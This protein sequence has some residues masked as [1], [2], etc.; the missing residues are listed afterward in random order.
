[1]FSNVFA[2]PGVFI[3][4]F[5]YLQFMQTEKQNTLNGNRI[6]KGSEAQ[7]DWEGVCGVNSQELFV[8]ESEIWMQ[9]VT[10]PSNLSTE[11]KNV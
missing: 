6:E 5:Y 9:L 3:L 7:E 4:W 8:L 2:C 1:M 10:A 11:D